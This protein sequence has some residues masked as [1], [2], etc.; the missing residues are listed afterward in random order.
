MTYEQRVAWQNWLLLTP[1]LILLICFVLIPAATAIYLSLTNEA[2]SGAAALHPR[3][4]GVR[5]YA[6]LFADD[7]LLEFAGHHR[8]L[9]LR[10]IHRRAVRPR[11]LLGHRAAIAGSFSDRCSSRQF[12]SLTPS[13][14][15]WPGFMWI[16]MLAGGEHSTLSRV[17][18]LFGVAPQ[19]WLQTA[20]LLMI[21]IV[22]TWRGIAFAMILM[23]SG[24]S[25][26]PAEV[27]EAARMDGATPRQIFW[28]ITL[29]LL[30]PTIFLY[31]LVSTVGTIAIFGL[32][33]SLTRG[34]PGGATEI[35][36]IYIYNQSFTAYQLGY[37]SAVAVIMLGI[38]MILGVIYV[39]ILKVKV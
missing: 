3:F 15:W 26:V 17:V 34:G 10:V 1:G 19:Q 25:A 14:R 30:R 33:Y 4:V 16:S 2:L 37:G 27:Y 6:R 5:N 28:R 21:I 38:S 39:R 23:M 12:C 13:R 20:P 11:A 24:L 18:G 31:M 29:P 36:G 22:N 7:G 35:I 8:D 32:V 9:R